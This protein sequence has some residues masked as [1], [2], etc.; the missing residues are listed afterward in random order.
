MKLKCRPARKNYMV[1][2]MSLTTGEVL[3]EEVNAQAVDL[4]FDVILPSVLELEHGAIVHRGYFVSDTISRQEAYANFASY[5]RALY[6]I[7]L[8]C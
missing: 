8:L 7:G 2:A 3:Q 4:G 6:A 1:L 5:I